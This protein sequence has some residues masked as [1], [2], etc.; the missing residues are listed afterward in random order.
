MSESPITIVIVAPM[1]P[2]E[3]I[4]PITT[5]N[6]P[7]AIVAQISVR[8]AAPLGNLGANRNRHR[9]EQNADQLD[10]QKR[11]AA[12]AQRRRSPRQGKDRHQL[13]KDE[14]GQ[15]REHTGDQRAW[16]LA[17]DDEH[18]YPLRKSVA[19]DPFLVA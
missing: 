2:A 9:E 19:G 16:I 4:G 14:C 7:I 6:E 11:L 1:R 12:V 8:A 18:R 17:E 3:N 5:P 15:R 10:D 13:K